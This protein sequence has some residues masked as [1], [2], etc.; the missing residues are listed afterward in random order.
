MALTDHPKAYGTAAIAVAFTAGILVTLGFKDVYPDLERRYRRERRS[1]PAP[2][3]NSEPW[4]RDS[5]FWGPPLQLEDHET[6]PPVHGHGDGLAADGIEAC[7]GNTPLIKIQ[8]L[9]EAT[10]RT[11]LARPSSSTAP[12]TAPRTASRST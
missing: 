12:A 6:N 7:I 5:I 8:S 11:I 9:S 2:N 3:A 1:P 4:R 10:G